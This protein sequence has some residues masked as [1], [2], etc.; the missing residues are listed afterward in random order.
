MK[1]IP[2]TH[3]FITAWI[4]FAS[5]S[6]LLLA[7]EVD[8]AVQ[9]AASSQGP[10]VYVPVPPPPPIKILTRAIY[11]R[12]TGDDGNDGLSV[13]KALRS[14]QK[15][16]DLTL[17]GDVV[18]FDGE[19]EKTS[20][21]APL[22]ITRSGEP[23][24]PITYAPAPGAKAIIRN[25]GAWDAIKIAGARHI[26]LQGFRVIGNAKNV[27]LEQAMA[28]KDNNLLPS[29]S[30]NGIAVMDDR[31]TKTPAAHIVV[32]NCEVSDCS[33]G[34]IFAN[35]VDYLTFENNVVYRCAFW[36]PNANS[37]LS[38]YQPTAIDDTTD[39]KIFIRNNVCFENYEYIPFI[40]SSKDPAKRKVTDGNGIIVDDYLNTQAFGG[41]SGK[42]YTGRTLVSNNICFANGGSGIHSF[43]SCN[44][45]FV[46]NYAADNNRHPALKDGQM[47]L[48]KSKNGRVFNNILVAPPGKP[49]NTD[50]GNENSI[51]DNNVYANIDGS[52]P[53]FRGEKANNIVAAPGLDLV[54]WSEGRR[55]FQATA[56]SPLRGAGLPFPEVK[57]DFFG[58][59]RN[60]E[61]PD[62]GPFV[63]GNP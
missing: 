32:R 36:S 57:T 52:T 13:E 18:F 47:F 29:T 3:I 4:L 46:N 45:D 51:Y 20:G 12:D 22:I 34:G 9:A 21:N 17:P 61:K 48:L 33:G 54:G 39:Y 53:F 16:A 49:V 24:K 56:D 43:K 31:Q 7:S 5:G 19:W 38:V 58:A 50:T 28:T 35:H 41:G 23:G 2:Q 60:T 10:G 37:G 44:V 26:V 55:V 59:L 11:V 42:E 8:G 40:H 27:T 1:V 30:G 63:L 62:I 6:K 25:S 15:A 14:P